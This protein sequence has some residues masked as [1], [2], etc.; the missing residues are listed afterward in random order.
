MGFLYVFSQKNLIKHSIGLSLVN[1]CVRL[2][3]DYTYQISLSEAVGSRCRLFITEG[4]LAQT[5]LL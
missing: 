4:T 3:P 2:F 5:Y 1:F